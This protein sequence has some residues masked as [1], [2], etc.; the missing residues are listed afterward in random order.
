ML[1]G[2]ADKKGGGLGGKWPP[3]DFSEDLVTVE[4]PSVAGVGYAL[5]GVN[6]E[7]VVVGL[8]VRPVGAPRLIQADF[9]TRSGRYAGVRAWY[10]VAL[11][12]FSSACCFGVHEVM[13]CVRG[14]FA[15]V[16]AGSK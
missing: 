8:R 3:A 7:N 15:D 2:T 13:C 14:G 9:K 6:D 5:L 4:L 1:V 12:D 11:E 16:C 10:V